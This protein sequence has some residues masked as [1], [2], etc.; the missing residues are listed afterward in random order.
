MI[1]RDRI[2]FLLRRIV[3]N[4]IKCVSQEESFSKPPSLAQTF[5]SET[6]LQFYHTLPSIDQF[7]E[8]LQNNACRADD[9]KCAERV[10]ALASA[11]SVAIDYDATSQTTMLSVFWSHPPSG[12]A[13][14]TEDITTKLGKTE[15]LEKVEVGVLSNERA[16]DAEDVSLGGFL[17]VV[18]QDSKLSEQLPA[19][20]KMQARLD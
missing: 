13:G 20:T 5:S 2:C 1:C 9:S 8:Y 4:D 16:T 10:S 3:G 18:G 17:A 12:A 19:S 6:S 11:D 7:A 14:W 15:K